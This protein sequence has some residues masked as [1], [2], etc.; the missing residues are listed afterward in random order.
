MKWRQDFLKNMSDISIGNRTIFTYNNLED[1]IYLSLVKVS[2]KFAN[3]V[4]IIDD[5]EIEYTY[6]QLLEM[7]DDFAS[8]L[9]TK[10]ITKATHVGIL[11]PTSIEYCITF[12][13]LIKIGAIVVLLPTKY[14]ET[15]IQSLLI[16]AEVT[17]LIISERYISYFN[18]IT[19]NKIWV[20]CETKANGLSHY[21]TTD[22]VH[23][24]KAN[25]NNDCVIIFTSGTTSTSKGVVIKNYNVMH[26]VETY[27]R[28]LNIG[29]DD[30]LI[31]PIPIYLITG[32]VAILGLSV[33]CGAT[34][35]LNRKFNADKVLNDIEKYNISFM[36]AS[37]AV[38]LLLLKEKHKMHDLS[39]LK[40]IACGAGNMPK[41]K[42]EE[43]H[44]WIPCAQFRT[45]YGLTETTSPATIFP[46][47]AYKHKYVG[48]VGLPIP[49][50]KFLIQDEKGNH[51]GANE[52]GEILIKGSVV[53]DRYYKR[54]DLNLK[55]DWL[56]TGDIGFFNEDGFLFITDRKKDIINRGGEKICS[57]DVENAIYDIKG[58]IEVAVI[59]IA[60]DLY[61]EE[62][63]AIVEKE[64]KASIT[65]D[66]IKKYLSTRLAK[67]E[68]PKTIVFVDSISKSA[69][70]KINKKYLKE[71]YTKRSLSNENA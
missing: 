50:T 41:A 38:F 45:I 14:K 51:L 18:H 36:H 24:E 32:L 25:K 60:N 57:I 58:I 17:N 15:E 21:C 33:H 23:F 47:N 31:L 37:P 46:T 12:F 68:I 48:S 65:E 61:G 69:N 22:Q 59:G 10:G 55:N 6:T 2:K 70:G 1:N 63:I 27:K 16:Q 67:Y 9:V 30:K 11:L 19:I 34:V 29:E 28:L 39:S 40:T 66:S 52:R 35:K 49:G 56:R 54:D 20:N 5:N 3:K 8:F 44:N 64:N 71:K 43:L 53:L 4:A 13:A 26:A 42:I 7:V 62:V